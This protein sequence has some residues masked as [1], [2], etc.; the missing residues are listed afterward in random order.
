VIKLGIEAPPDVRI[1]RGELSDWVESASKS[2]A[3]PPRPAEA[4]AV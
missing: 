1:L 4:I 3:H 2:D